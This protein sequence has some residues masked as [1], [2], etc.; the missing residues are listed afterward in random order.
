MVSNRSD[1]KDVAR[2]D[3]VASTSVEIF[4]GV[5]RIDAPTDVQAT[6]KC[7]VFHPVDDGY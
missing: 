5:R 7:P 6:R 1:L 3:D 2:D 4:H